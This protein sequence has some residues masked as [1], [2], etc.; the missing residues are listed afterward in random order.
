M[1]SSTYILGLVAILASS[2]SSAHAHKHASSFGARG[3]ENVLDRR[4]NALEVG[5]FKSKEGHTYEYSFNW[6]SDGECAKKC[7]AKKKASMILNGSDCFCGDMHPRKKDK[8]DDAK[9]SFPCPGWPS[10]MC[11]SGTDEYFSVW[12][13]GIK[14]I[15][16]YV[17]EDDEIAASKSSSAAAAASATKTAAHDQPSPA[18]V[19]VGG[20]TVVVTPSS[21]ADEEKK[22]SGPNKAG[23]A[24]GVVVGVIVIA[25]AAG[26]IWFFLR[27]KRRNELEE[28]YKRQAAIKAFVTPAETSTF[29][30]RLD[31][32]VMRRMSDGSIADNQDYSRR[33]L[34]VTN[35]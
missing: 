26:G 15:V 30:T 9:C 24:A 35:A 16:E 12:K 22:D 6:M 20:Q 32:A 33:I 13:T 17:G 31:P 3:V 21:D 27:K 2:V 28:E 10:V 18:V 4:Q 14:T 29:D 34:K 11:G 19:T 8:V 7:Q 1:V 25:A 5:C 23:I